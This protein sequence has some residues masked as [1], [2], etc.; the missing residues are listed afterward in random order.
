R[1]ANVITKLSIQLEI[2]DAASKGLMLQVSLSTCGGIERIQSLAG[3]GGASKCSVCF[4]GINR[5]CLESTR[6][7]TADFP[8]TSNWPHEGLTVTYTTVCFCSSGFFV[9]WIDGKLLHPAKSW[10]RVD[11]LPISNASST[12]A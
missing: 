9:C 6:F 3:N 7:S 11:S 2:K 1:S 12:T 4:P 8:S 5:R 10:V